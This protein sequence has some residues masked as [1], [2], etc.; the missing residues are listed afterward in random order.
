MGEGR[1]QPC[2]GS[3]PGHGGR[4][5]RCVELNQWGRNVTERERDGASIAVLHRM[6]AYIREEALR[7]RVMDVAVLLEHAEEA[8][9]AF[10]PATL[11]A[12]PSRVAPP[13]AGRVEH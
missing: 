12:R 1:P 5:A 3:W 7:L 4:G 9:T 11:G 6:I 13:D 8:V 2:P 10:S